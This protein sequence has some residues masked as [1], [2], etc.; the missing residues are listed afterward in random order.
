[1]NHYAITSLFASVVLLAACGGGGSGGSEAPA[2]PAGSPSAP[3]PSPAPSAYDAHQAWVNLLSTS[4]S[5]VVNGVGSDAKSYQLTLAT[6]PG[7]AAVFPVTGVMAAKANLRNRLM[8]G[9]TL[10][11][12]VLNEQFFDIEYRMLGSRVSTD[13]GTPDCSKTDVVAALPASG[14][15]PGASG[16]LYAATTLSDCSSSATALGTSYH[17]WSLLGEGGVVY[18]CI[19]SSN[20]FMGEATDRL[21]ETCVETDAAGTLGQR[22]RIRLVLP[23]FSVTAT[24]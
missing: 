23:G 8:Q 5:W 9:A 2:P 18:L 20:R 16:P 22:A 19:A 7:G 10:M 1:M 13:V 6:E 12:D 21:S 24:N 4:R 17:T 15:A 14:V 11:Q 3:A